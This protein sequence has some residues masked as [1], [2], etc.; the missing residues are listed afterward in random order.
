MRRTF[1]AVTRL[2]LR[3]SLNQPVLLLVEDLHWLDSETQAWLTL[4]SDRVASARLL[5]LVNYRPEY[6]HGWGSKTYYTQ[7][8]LD[9]LGPQEAQELLTALL[10][11]STALQP[12]T[13][14]ILAKT[15]RNPFFMEEM[16][17]T[18]VD[19]GVLRRDPAGG[20]HLVAPVTSGALAALQLPPTVQ[21][22]LAARI[23][24]LPA[25][26]KT[27]LQ[28]LAVLGKEFAWSLLTVVA[29]QPED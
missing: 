6:Q 17:Q 9:P 27:L 7:L 26:V 18:L 28:T 11:D 19:Q 4:F 14:F 21:G 15:E 3:E 23:D 22:V 8:R 12:L 1:E 10:G 24:R 20:M 13:Q 29:D 2:L 5:L 25:D 16:V